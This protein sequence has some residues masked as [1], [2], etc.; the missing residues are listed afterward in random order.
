MEDALAVQ[1]LQASGDVQRQA[2]PHTPRQ[3]HVTVQ[4]LLQ[5]PSIDVLCQ[6][7]E[8]SLLYT[9]TQKPEDV[10]MAESVH[11][12]HLSQHV[13][14]VAGQSVHLQ[15]HHLACRSVLHLEDF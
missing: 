12:L 6:G 14:L 13:G 11:Q 8:L 9:H 10:G 4:E 3:E 1:V 15:G 5:V 2:R 7:M